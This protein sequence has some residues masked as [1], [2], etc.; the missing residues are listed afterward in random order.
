MITNNDIMRRIRYVFDFDDTKM[1]S[2]FTLADQEATRAEISSWLKKDDHPDFG[3][4]IDEQLAVFLN[5]LIIEKRGKKDGPPAP[6]E[7]RLSNNV[8]LRKLKIALNM[9]DDDIIE[10]LELTDK[11]ISKHE[12]SAFF[13]KPNHKH[14]RICQDQLLRNFLQGLQIKYRGE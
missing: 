2:L 12:L 7:K 10:I 9:K 5:G 3:E 6:V 4:L 11:H 14:Y 1:M 13:R 8:I